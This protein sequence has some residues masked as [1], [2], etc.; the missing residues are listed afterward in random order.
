MLGIEA[1]ISA[2]GEA[3]QLAVHAGYAGRDAWHI[4]RHMSAQKLSAQVG[5]CASCAAARCTG[6]ATE[7]ARTRILQ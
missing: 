4:V 6:D 7:I 1:S 2:I 3:R 5:Q